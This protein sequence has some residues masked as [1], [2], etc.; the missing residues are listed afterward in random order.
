M[1][2][3]AMSDDLAAVGG[4]LRK[5]DLFV[6][7]WAEA[8]TKRGVGHGDCF[9]VL[10]MEPRLPGE[11]ASD[12]WSRSR[13]ARERDNDCLSVESYGFCVAMGS[14]LK[15]NLE[16]T[17]S[18]NI[19]AS[20]EIGCTVPRFDE[21]YVSYATRHLAAD[22]AERLLRA[23]AALSDLMPSCAV[24]LGADLEP[25]FFA[26]EGDSDDYGLTAKDALLLVNE[27]GAFLC[28]LSHR[29]GEDDIVCFDGP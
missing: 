29:M 17:L 4:S 27:L 12:W 13:H 11:S 14:Y 5:R 25:A 6:P 26:C 15:E 1:S 22:A 16:E 8:G 20:A 21:Y 7:T 3:V 10:L 19:D 2:M 24:K 18:A 23:A 28:D 9:N